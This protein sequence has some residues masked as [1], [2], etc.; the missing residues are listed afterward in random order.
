MKEIK[1]ILG[2][3]VLLLIVQPIFSQPNQGAVIPTGKKFHIQSAMNYNRDNGGY[4]D[5][6]GKPTTIAR[7][8]NIQVWALDDGIDRFF[9]LIE[10]EEQGFYEI[11]VGNTSNSRVDIVRGSAEN[12]TNV[13]TWDQNNNNAQRFLFEHLG[14]GRFKIH[15]RNGR[16]LC[17]KDRV[18][19]NGSN[20]HIWGNH[21]GVWMEW[22][23]VDPDTKK[24][25]VP[26]KNQPVVAKVKGEEM[27]EGTLFFIQSAMN[28]G[29]DNRGYW[30]LPGTGSAALVKGKNFQVWGLDDGPDRLFHLSKA[31]NGQYY[32]I[33][34]GGHG[35]NDFVLDLKSNNT[36]NGTN[37]IIWELNNQAAQDFYFE[38]L[39]EGRF[40][41]YHRSGKPVTLK[42]RKN[43][44]GSQLVIWDNHSGMWNEWYIIDSESKEVYIP[45]KSRLKSRQ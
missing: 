44:N 39:G 13:Q 22:Y 9:T 4:W 30:D 6:P 40:K 8:S 10:S 45:G 16:V 41:I 18:S 24:A 27:P 7:G 20:V 12:A 26:T 36:T 34:V 32:N 3:L 33:Y 14:N 15:T 37:F 19:T 23:L 11:Q 17:L 2:L 43:D 31:K 42:D 28:Y 21:D 35:K 38:H 29:R 5:I 1:K 25:F